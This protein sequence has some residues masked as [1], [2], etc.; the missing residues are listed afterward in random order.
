MSPH[1]KHHKNSGVTY[2]KGGDSTPDVAVNDVTVGHGLLYNYDSWMTLF[3]Y[4]LKY[5]DGEESIVDYTH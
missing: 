3:D 2:Y 4:P 5:W 1:F